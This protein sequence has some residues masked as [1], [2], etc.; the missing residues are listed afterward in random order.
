MVDKKVV[1]QPRKEAVTRSKP[2][3]VMAIKKND[4]TKLDR[5]MKA[6]FPIDEP[7]QSFGEQSPLMFAASV[8]E[9]ECLELLLEY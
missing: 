5:I 2:F 4:T 3:L 9:T 1:K 6:G 8:G 7:I